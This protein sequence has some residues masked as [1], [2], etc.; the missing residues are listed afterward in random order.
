MIGRCVEDRRPVTQS[1]T[2]ETHWK[3]KSDEADKANIV[4]KITAYK[5]DRFP[6]HQAHERDRT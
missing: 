5:A 6:L 3:R 2:R 4:R 1:A